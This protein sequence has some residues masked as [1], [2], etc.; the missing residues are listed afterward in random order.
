MNQL[1]CL[2]CRHCVLLPQTDFTQRGTSIHCGA[3]PVGEETGPRVVNF[4]GCPQA[5][6]MPRSGT[7]LRYSKV[8][9]E[10]LRQMMPRTDDKNGIARLMNRSVMS[11]KHHCAKLKLK[12]PRSAEA[13]K[14]S[15]DIARN[16]N[17]S[18]F[19]VA[20]KEYICAVSR[21]DKWPGEGGVKKGARKAAH[22][23]KRNA[24]VARVAELGPAKKWNSITHFVYR[25]SPAY[26]R[27][28]KRA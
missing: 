21:S 16:A 14:R 28:N 7:G 25:Q 11:I 3:R 10:F 22:S 19:T 17:P 9:D 15:S 8:A 23:R 18:A 12:Y 13:I 4:E 2:Q 24:I 6:P 26:Q 1:N 20:Q 27:K 5:A